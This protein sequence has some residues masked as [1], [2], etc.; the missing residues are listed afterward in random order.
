MTPGQARDGDGLQRRAS[1]RAP[2][3]RELHLIAPPGFPGRWPFVVVSGTGRSSRGGRSQPGS[4]A[5]SPFR[6]DPPE[7]PPAAALATLPSA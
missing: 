1:G 5:R 6:C 7:R 4:G 3:M 2:A